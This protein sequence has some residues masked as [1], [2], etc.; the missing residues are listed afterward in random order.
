[1]DL[2]TPER[3]RELASVA[4]SGTGADALIATLISQVS[5]VA[6]KYMRRHGPKLERTEVY[7]LRPRRSSVLL[8]GAPIDPA[9]DVEV[10]VDDDLPPTSDPLESTDFILNA[11]GG[12]LQLLDYP[13]REASRRSRTT[14]YVQIQY[15]AGLAEDTDALVADPDFADLVGAVTMQVQ[16]L[17][18]R[19]DKLGGDTR[20]SMGGGVFSSEKRSEYALLPD[21]E[22]VLKSYRRSPL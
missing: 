5:T 3:V 11:D 9:E 17:Y 15:T 1:M 16:H 7:V 6:L 2:T 4:S 10:Y 20:V 21:V 8:D 19:R 18:E 22:R 12:W 13:W 14:L